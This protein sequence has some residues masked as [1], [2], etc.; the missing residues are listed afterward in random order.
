[1]TSKEFSDYAE[2]PENAHRFLEL[3]DGEVIEKMPSFTPSELA[4]MLIFYLRLYLRDHPIGRL[5]APDDMYVM[6]DENS[7]IPNVGF[8]SNER[9]GARPDRAVLVPPDLAVEIKSPTDRLRA[10]RRKA[11]RYLELGTRVV[12]LVVPETQ[13]IEVYTADSDV[14]TLAA[15]N[16]LDGGTVLPGFSVKVSDIFAVLKD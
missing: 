8:I 16:L 14:I 5:S 1:M 13:T 4:T 2:L 7:F 3:I 11:E 12:W 15:D 10:V 9:F 6:D